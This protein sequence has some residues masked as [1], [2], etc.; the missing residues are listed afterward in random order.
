MLVSV[1]TNQFLNGRL[2][3]TVLKGATIKEMNMLHIRLE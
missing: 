3:F 2:C 1:V